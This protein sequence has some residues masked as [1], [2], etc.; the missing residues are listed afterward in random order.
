MNISR[1]SFKANYIGP[2]AFLTKSSNANGSAAIVPGSFVELDPKN[3]IDVDSIADVSANWGFFDSLAYDVFDDMERINKNLM[4]YKE[5]SKF[6]AMTLQQSNFE[7]LEPEKVLG[8]TEVSKKDESTIKI[9][10]L[11][12]DPSNTRNKASAKFK[13]LGTNFLNY[14]KNIY[15]N[16]DIYLRSTDSAKKFYKFNGFVKFKKNTNE[17]IYRVKPK[18]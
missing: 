10:Y 14:I 12:V 15:P 7:E 9:N 2:M 5:D 13:R 6:Y 1:V 8:V 3:N 17:Y 4:R 11:Q 18:V 16:N